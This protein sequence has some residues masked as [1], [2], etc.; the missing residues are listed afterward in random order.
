MGK[1]DILNTAL[2]ARIPLDVVTA[3]RQPCRPRVLALVDGLSWQ[4]SDGFGLWR[5]LHAITTA[6]GVTNKPALTLAHRNTHP[7]ATVTVGTDTYTIQN[8]FS[9]ATATPAVTLANY[10]QIWIFGIGSGAF[11]L[12]NAEVGVISEFMNGGG[13][14]FA[15]GDHAALGRA[16]CGSLPRIRHMREWRDAGS[17]GV[18]M[19]TESDAALAV[20][21]IDTVVNPGANALYEFADQSD[22]IPQRIY[23]NYK[24]TDTDGLG[25]TGWEATAHP[26]LMLPGAMTVRSS[27]NPAG[28][29]AGFTLDI[30]VLPDHPHESV[31]YEVTSAATLGGS[32]SLVGQNFAE[33]QPNAASPAQRVAPAIV[34][35]AVS[36]GRS[37]FNSVW[38][39]PVRPRV[40]GILSAYDGRQAQA[41][42]GKTQRPGRI[43]CDSTWH[44]YVNVNLDGTGSGRT[45]LGTGSGS[46]F[47]PS[48]DLEKIYAFYRNTV[49]WLQPA[50]R[51]WCRTF[52]D[53]V[54]VRLSPAIFEELIDAERLTGWRELVGLGREAKAILT[55]VHGAEAV[56]DDILGLLAAEPRTQGVAD[57]LGS[58]DIAR[59]AFSRDE[60]VDGVLGGL[61]VEMARLLPDGFDPAMA[62][63]VLARG[64]AG[65]VKAL[66]RRLAATVEKGVAYQAERMERSL[67]VARR[68]TVGATAD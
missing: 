12:S 51:V 9:F 19:G 23:P 15:T 27:A 37:V 56:R 47:V 34:A 14:V 53:L 54:A 5:F 49:R 11:S 66:Q 61:L 21:R 6:P 29:S 28:A 20:N 68:M 32:Y 4:A 18:P 10:D 67:K 17:G 65:H 30:N 35:Y 64:P 60:L 26:L 8:N 22:E 25:G 57:L 7:T 52:W 55:Q 41:Y 59:T 3:W 1:F 13:G 42:P 24:V 43:V 62:E 38:K 40:F 50:N 44:H 63:E 31:C 48:P 16:L 2:E 58:D 46:A 45:G 33:Y 39:P 36:G